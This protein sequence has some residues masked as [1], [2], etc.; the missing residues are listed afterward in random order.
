[1]G[2]FTALPIALGWVTMNLRG[3]VQRGIGVASM[4]AFGNCGG[5]VATFTFLARD[6][7]KYKTGYA[8]MLGSLTLAAAAQVGY[9]AIVFRR[10]KEKRGIPEE[11][12]NR[13]ENKRVWKAML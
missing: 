12:L 9:A 6:A 8:V 4:A 5:F 10:N 3:P 13:S 1:M 11:D 7:P 2:T